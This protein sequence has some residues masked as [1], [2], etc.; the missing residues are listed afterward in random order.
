MEY[1]S[2]YR[3]NSE[4]RLCPAIRKNFIRWYK[5]YLLQLVW[6]KNNATA[7]LKMKWRLLLHYIV[8]S[9]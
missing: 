7:F 1:Y 6:Y 2:R 3:I 8:I 5:S 4:C 9:I